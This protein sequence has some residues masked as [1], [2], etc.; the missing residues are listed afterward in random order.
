MIG[1]HLFTDETNLTKMN[2]K[3]KF[4]DNN[5]HGNHQT[6]S[7]DVVILICDSC[8]EKNLPAAP[9]LAVTTIWWNVEM[10]NIHTLIG[11]TAIIATCQVLWIDDIKLVTS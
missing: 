3:Q 9:F 11:Y 5:G 1:C 8:I 2:I 7:F 10:R 4:H 6:A